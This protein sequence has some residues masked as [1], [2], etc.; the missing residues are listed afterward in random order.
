MSS[1]LPPL[2][3]SASSSVTSAYLGGLPII[4]LLLLL[5]L[6]VAKQAS[7]NM[8]SVRYRRL[9]ACLD[10]GVLPLALCALAISANEISRIL[11]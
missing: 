11:S 5:V 8:S 10:V 1:L 6:L 9:S 2:T 7:V 4:A 3:E